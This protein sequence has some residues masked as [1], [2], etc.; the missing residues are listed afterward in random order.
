[1]FTETVPPQCRRP[2]PVVVIVDALDGDPDTPRPNGSADDGRTARRLAATI[3]RLVSAGEL[4]VGARLPTVR[5]L[6]R[7]LGVSPTTVSEA[8]RRLA[9]V[10]AIETRGRNGTFVRQ[11]TGPGGPR[12]YRQ[13]TEGPGHFALDLSSGTPDPDL[14]PDLAPIVAKVSRQSLT[15]SY[16]DSP[17]L[18]ALEEE[19]RATWPFE[20]EAIT[21]VDGAL[22]ALDRV[23]GVA[24]RLGDRV[25]VEHPGFPPML[26][27]LERLSCDVVGVDVD[28]EGLDVTQLRAVIATGAPAAVILQPR[29]QNPAGVAM[30]RRRAKAIAEVLR[31]ADTLVVED[32]HANV[33]SSARLTS[34]GTWLPR[35]TVH[36]RSFSKSHGPDLRLAAVGGAG[37]V[38]TAVENRRLLGPGWSSRILQSVLLELIR[39][40]ET[41]STLATA[42][43]AYAARRRA[44]SEVLVERGVEVTGTD[45]INLWMG[46]DDERAAVVALAAQGIGVAPG[47]PFLVRPDSDH[48]RITVG[49]L[50]P[51][52]G[53]ARVAEQLAAAAKLGHARHARSTARHR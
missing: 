52:R 18:P 53:L 24:L 19:L 51:E 50:S 32:D 41:T 47:A 43:R 11:P 46:V 49:V 10:G 42:R 1:M 31:P 16:L 33:I 35:R 36:I 9:D 34:V 20:P 3:G 13:I 28:S 25:V 39:H 38:V 21:V 44:V 14:L 26:D 37:D 2:D 15:S 5:E 4:E 22:D 30:S 48:L 29:A 23:A 8:W 7:K 12:R 45:G 27:L 17:V 6:A 40:A